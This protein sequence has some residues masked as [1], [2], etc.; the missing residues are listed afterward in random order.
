MTRQIAFYKI[1]LYQNST[2]PPPN[3]DFLCYFK[4]LLIYTP[5]QKPCVLN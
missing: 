2:Q 4:T 5:Y 1:Q 3:G